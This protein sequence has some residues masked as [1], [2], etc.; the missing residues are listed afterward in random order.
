MNKLIQRTFENRGYTE[1]FIRDIN[2]PSYDLLKDIDVI[3][4]KLHEIFDSHAV[5]TIY[6][7]F[8][9]DGISSGNIWFAGLAE[10]GFCVNLFVPDTKQGYG[11]S[12]SEVDSIMKSYP[13]TNTI[14]T[15]DNGISA[16]A[17]AD[18]CKQIGIE[19]I[20]TDHHKQKI[21]A[22]ADIIIDPMRLD[23]T[24]AHPAICGA[25][26]SYQI[27]QHYADLY[28]TSYMQSQISRLRV[29][30]GI[31]IMCCSILYPYHFI[32]RLIL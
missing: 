9:V 21:V 29:F 15:C 26:V 24:Y 13:N 17:A 12:V 25:F 11:L 22:N 5:I 4:V 20:V 18:Y 23:E 14:I 8:D 30:A 28:C 32:L 2:N 7:D 6:P 10:L 1:Q 31:G 27:I 3:S 16:Y 19:L